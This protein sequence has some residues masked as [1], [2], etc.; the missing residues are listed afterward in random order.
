MNRLKSLR[1]ERGLFQSDI[2]KVLGISVAAVGFY[3]NEKRDM[4]PDTILKLAEYF[5]V[6]TDYLLGK[7]DLRQPISQE[8]FEKNLLSSKFAEKYNKL[9]KEQRKTIDSLFEVWEKE[10]RE[11]NK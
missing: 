3:E 11:E 8:A 1:E 10:N 7:T 9:T 6:T 4:S 5:N 2:A